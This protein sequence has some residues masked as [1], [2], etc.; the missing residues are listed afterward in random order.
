MNASC[1]R[2]CVGRFPSLIDVDDLVQET[3]ARL[4]RARE[5]GQATLTRAYLFVIARNVA[6]DLIRRNKT[7]SVECLGDIERL[8]VVEK[9]PMPPRRSAMNRN[10]NCSPKPCARCRRAAVKFSRCAAS[11]GFPIARLRKGSGSPKAP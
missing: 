10:S 2:T 9:G 1:A 6:L 8:S 5:S 11:K 4:L 3:Y 7:V